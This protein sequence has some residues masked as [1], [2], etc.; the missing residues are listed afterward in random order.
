MRKFAEWP[1]PWRKWIVG[2]LLLAAAGAAIAVWLLREPPRENVLRANG[3]ATVALMVFTQPFPLDP[4]P[5]GWRHAKFWTRAPMQMSFA[6]KAGVNA[7][8]VETSASASMLFRHVD[9]AVDEY[10][11]LQWRW[12]I[13]TP[14]RSDRDERTREG[15][16]HPARFFV[17]LQTPDN[18]QRRF[19]IIW[20]N[21]LHRGD[22]KF[23]GGFPHYVADGGDENIGQWRDEQIDLADIAQLF[24]PGEKGLRL[25]D[26]AVFCD[27][28]DTQTSSLAWIG[29]VGLVRR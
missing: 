3:A 15:D 10:P 24:W 5:P 18:K 2:A 20:G 11:V 13:E 6:N 9:I 27:S 26:I 19:E 29:D 1:G 21:R 7:L 16:D 8:R 4:P 23:I 14:I 17:V 12:F 28:D 22:T 25:V